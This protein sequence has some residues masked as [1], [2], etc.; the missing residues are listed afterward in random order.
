MKTSTSYGAQVTFRV[1]SPGAEEEIWKDLAA[2]GEES[3]ESSGCNFGPVAIK[4]D[5][6][7][8][9]IQAIERGYV[10]LLERYDEARKDAVAQ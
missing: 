5:D 2:M 8:A 6:Q 10:A 7:K 3:D 1:W 9:F 4:D